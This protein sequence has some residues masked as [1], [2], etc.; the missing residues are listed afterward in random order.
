MTPLVDRVQSPPWALRFDTRCATK[1]CLDIMSILQSVSEAVVLDSG[2]RA[3]FTIKAA[4]H[5][6][7]RSFRRNL[8]GNVK[9]DGSIDWR[10]PR[11]AFAAG[12]GKETDFIT[13]YQVD[14]EPYQLNID[15][16]D[17]I[18]GKGNPVMITNLP[19]I[20]LG[21][22]PVVKAFRAMYGSERH[23]RGDSVDVETG[24]VSEDIAVEE[25]AWA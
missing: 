17:R 13:I 1:L 24:E 19:V 6:M 15:G 5:A 4:S 9:E 22:E 8:W 14:V 20:T 25:G 10:Y 21:D 2:D 11:D 18:D 3:Y 23:L 7:D 12:E 16:E